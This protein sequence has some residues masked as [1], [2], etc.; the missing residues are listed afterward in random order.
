MDSELFDRALQNGEAVLN[1]GQRN[2]FRDAR[3][4]Y[5]SA[6]MGM[7]YRLAALKEAEKRAMAAVH[8]GH[9][10]LKLQ[11]ELGNFAF[12]AQAVVECGCYAAWALGSH[13]EPRTFPFAMLPRRDRRKVSPPE[14]R[15]RFSRRFRKSQLAKHLR[16]SLDSKQWQVL[17][18][19]RI[20]LFHR[21]SDGLHV[22]SVGPVHRVAR[23]GGNS[24]GTFSDD[25]SGSALH[26][27][28]Q[29]VTMWATE[30]L[31]S[32]NALVASQRGPN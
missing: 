14:T 21:A 32:L 28:R 12:N 2:R 9:D 23:R 29:W 5:G 6:L 27:R 11:I 19:E 25:I 30:L 13:Y 31:E 15:K 7:C 18:R 17:S 8:P 3:S 20:T 4:E 10:S 1:R 16:T 22:Y 26:E 24:K